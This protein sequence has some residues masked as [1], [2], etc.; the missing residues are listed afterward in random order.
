[1]NLT[2]YQ[3]DF[4][5]CHFFENPKFD[6]SVNIAKSLL[7]N[8]Y[9]ITTMQGANIWSG[10][11]GNFISKVEAPEYVNC[12]K[13]VFDLKMFL[14]CNWVKEIIESKNDDIIETYLGLQKK[15]EELEKLLTFE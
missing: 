1:M 9:C 8:G 5:A 15:S 7:K 3:I 4:L 10:G 6:G 12:I 11:V 14:S 2:D 13:L